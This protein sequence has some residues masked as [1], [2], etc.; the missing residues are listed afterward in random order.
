MAVPAGTDLDPSHPLSISTF[1]SIIPNVDAILEILLEQGTS[2]SP[3]GNVEA[4]AQVAQQV[5]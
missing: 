1:R 3:P 4:S 5:S 2:D